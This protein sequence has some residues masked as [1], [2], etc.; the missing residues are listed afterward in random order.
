MK[1]EKNNID[2]NSPRV[3]VGTYHKYASGDLFGAWLD[4]DNYAGA[5][6]FLNACRELHKD[7][8]DPEF[9]LQDYENMPAEL[10]HE[11]ASVEQIA[12]MIDYAALDDYDKEMID[13]WLDIRSAEGSI[14]DM[15]EAAQDAFFCKVDDT[16]S[17]A[18]RA[19]AEY[20]ADEKLIE[21]PEHLWNYFDFE[22]YGRDLSMEMTMSADGYVFRDC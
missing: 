9:M 4:L 11:S 8:K 5:D 22:A 3:Y 1:T 18:W 15:L 10:Y 16:S 13:A 14:S 12:S 21:I 6:E 20:C 17:T 19:V 7:E 2:S